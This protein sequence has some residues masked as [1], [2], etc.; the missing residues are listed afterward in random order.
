MWEV[1]NDELTVKALFRRRADLKRETFRLLS[2]I[3]YWAYERNKRLEI[4][5]RLQRW[6]E[7]LLRIQ[8]RLGINNFDLLIKWKGERFYK[9]IN[10]LSFEDIPNLN[11]S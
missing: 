6:K 9:S 3:P 4:L 7:K 2:Y 10:I 1:F 5:C 11:F 8:I